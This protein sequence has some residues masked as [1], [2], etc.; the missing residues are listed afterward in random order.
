LSVSDDLEENL[1][2]LAKRHRELSAAPI[3]WFGT[4]HHA[5]QRWLMQKGKDKHGK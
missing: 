5:A 3:N 1:R 2:S 4:Y